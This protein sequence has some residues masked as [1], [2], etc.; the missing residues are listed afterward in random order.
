[1]RFNEV[2]P[3][4]ILQDEVHRFAGEPDEV[5]DISL[6]QSEGNDDP[7]G[8]VN[9]VMNREVDQHVRDSRMGA[10]EEELLNPVSIHPQLPADQPGG[11]VGQTRRFSHQPSE[12]FALDG[13]GHRVLIRFRDVISRT[14]IDY[15]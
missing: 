12:G 15:R 3:S 10:L 11:F 4:E 9:A 6:A 2:A 7:L 8:I 13:V 5:G 1:M 14:R